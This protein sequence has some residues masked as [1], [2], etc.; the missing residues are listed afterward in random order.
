MKKLVLLALF[1]ILAPGCATTADLA[2]YSTQERISVEKSKAEVEKYKAIASLAN[3]SD[4]ARVAG[5]MAL[6]LGGNPQQNQSQHI[7]A[8]KSASDTV[9]QY[10]SIL[11]PVAV[12][13]YGIGKN[14]DVAI[15]SSQMARDVAVSTNQTFQSMA[16]SIQA[17]GAVTT[18]NQTLSGS[19]TLGSGA[20]STTDNHAVDNTPVVITPVVIPPVVQITPVVITPAAPAQ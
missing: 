10:L 2:Y 15:N 18:T 8:P 13:A 19:G 7:A 17:P 9:L 16:S 14:A 6:A 12:Q 20:Y 1:A 3:G 5:V 11:A 4:A